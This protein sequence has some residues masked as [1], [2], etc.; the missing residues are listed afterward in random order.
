MST[1]HAC[2]QQL[3]EEGADPEAWLAQQVAARS[4]VEVTYGTQVGLPWTASRS[5]RN[6]PCCD[7]ARGS[8]AGVDILIMLPF[9]LCG[10]WASPPGGQLM[11]AMHDVQAAGTGAVCALCITRHPPAAAAQVLT[12]LNAAVE[13]CGPL[14]DHRPLCCQ[15]GFLTPQASLM[16]LRHVMP[17]STVS[18]LGLI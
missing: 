5:T 10:S 16:M 8:T 11:C 18:E 4:C 9:T 15:V 13:A 6:G 14:R 2:R 3:A 12:E 1:L 17:G 7:A